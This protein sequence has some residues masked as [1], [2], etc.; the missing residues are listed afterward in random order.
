M[1][2]NLVTVLS[3]I[4]AII[5]AFF[6]SASSIYLVLVGVLFL[7]LSTILDY[8][9]GEVARYNKSGT[10]TGSFLDWY[11][12]YVISSATFIGLAFGALSIK[13]NMLMVL[14]SILAIVRPI[15]D[16][17]IIS[18]GWTVI[19]WT[20]L[21]ELK[22]G[23]ENMKTFKWDFIKKGKIAT[24]VESIKLSTGFRNKLN[25][26][27]YWWLRFITVGIFQHFWAPCLL[28][29]LTLLQI[30]INLT[31]LSEFDFRPLLIIYS[32]IVGPLY[33]IY[34]VALLVKSNAFEDGY[35]RL[36]ENT[37]KINIPDDYFF[38]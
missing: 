25:K 12:Q 5:G 32:G 13:S 35:N 1:T 27:I 14:F 37:K 19:C 24:N 31:G 11:M 38:Y 7:S 21:E 9:D 26:H 34:K 17:T 15:M 18:G 33:I 22:S 29:L 6:L 2:A 8:S 28:L 10:I 20:R 3:G 4:V 23:R 36:F 30:I 16:Y